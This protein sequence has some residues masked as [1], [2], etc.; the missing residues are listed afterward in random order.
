MRRAFTL[1][2]LLLLLAVIAVLLA[3]LLPAITQARWRADFTREAATCKAQLADQYAA[4]LITTSQYVDRQTILIGSTLPHRVAVAG[5]ATAAVALNSQQRAALDRAF[6]WIDAGIARCAERPVMAIRNP[7]IFA[8][9]ETNFRLVRLGMLALKPDPN[10]PEP[11]ALSYTAD[12]LH[13]I[14]QCVSD[15]WGG[16]IYPLAYWYGLPSL[17]DEAD[18]MFRPATFSG[19]WPRMLA[20]R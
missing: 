6:P 1:V 18:L 16:E 4:G 20:A 13:Y 9:E 7:G 5:F 15:P 3:L 17:R 8:A 14:T 19:M 11:P 12:A 2:E 10:R